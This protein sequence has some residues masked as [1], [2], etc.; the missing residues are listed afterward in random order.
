MRRPGSCV[1]ARRP[2]GGRR[3][4]RRSAREA[5]GR[6][7]RHHRPVPRHQRAGPAHLGHAR[8][9]ACRRCSA[10]GRSTIGG[11]AIAWQKIGALI[12]LGVEAVGLL[13]ALPEDADRPGHAGG[14]VQ[15][16]VVGAGRHPG[17]P[18]FLMLGWGLAAALG[19]VAGMFTAPDRG[20]GLQP[21]AADADLRVRRHHARRVRLARRRGGRR[22]ASSASLTEVVPQVRRSGSR[23]CRWRPAFTLILLVLLF[24]P[25]GLFGRKQVTTGM[26]TVPLSEHRVG[27][28]R[29]IGSPGESWRG[30]SWRS[31]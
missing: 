5:A 17:R 29:R 19:A 28:Q 18:R 3:A 6:R 9:R 2:P 15:L 10:P 30:S 27:G 25:E 12:V 31:C 26:T 22:S 16:G 14:R 8:P 4:R 1:G 7:H 24:R 20:L 13:A 21:H 23:R 11:V